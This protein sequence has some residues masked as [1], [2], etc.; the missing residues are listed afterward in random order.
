MIDRSV[1]DWLRATINNAVDLFDKEFTND[2]DVRI[3]FGFQS[4]QALQ[5]PTAAAKSVPNYGYQSYDDLRAA[6]AQGSVASR[7]AATGMPV[8]DPTPEGGRGN[9]FKVPF[10]LEK[11]L[12]LEDPSINP[13]L[14]D[15][16]VTLNSDKDWNAAPSVDPAM[17]I[18]TTGVIE[19]E[20]TEILGRVGILGRN[21][22]YG[23]T[24]YGPMDLFRFDRSSR[25]V[26]RDFS[27]VPG[28]YFSLR[29]NV[30]IERFNNLS[31]D[32][33]D[34][35]Y[36][37]S[38]AVAQDVF[39]AGDPEAQAYFSRNDLTVMRS[40]GY[41]VSR[42]IVNGSASYP[43]RT[44]SKRAFAPGADVGQPRFV[45]QPHAAHEASPGDGEQRVPA[46]PSSDFVC[47]VDM[48]HDP[49]ASVPA[50]S[51]ATSHV[52]STGLENLGAPAPHHLSARHLE[53]CVT[54]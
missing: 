37:G 10:A 13:R 34:W 43:A 50:A 17:S 40:L 11:A 28:S 31:G 16:A 7:Y 22:G 35:S 20:I 6:L 36:T 51:A 29:G 44:A 21:D 8:D 19:H 24:L 52:T 30:A 5:A 54:W 38:Y 41:T 1:P 26:R 4:F 42:S 39:D 12:G 14:N 3:E 48:L 2:I 9:V 18:D 47:V 49:H 32:L 33:A 23:N 27:P 53:G 46:L 25:A 45:F 15:G